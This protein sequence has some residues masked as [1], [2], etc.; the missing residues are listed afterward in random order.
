MEL[1]KLHDDFE[2]RGVS[3]LAISSDNAERTAEMAKKINARN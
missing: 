1:E 3:P 2:R